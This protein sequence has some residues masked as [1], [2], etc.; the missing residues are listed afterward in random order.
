MYVTINE[1][2][3]LFR[4]RSLNVAKALVVAEQQGFCAQSAK[5]TCA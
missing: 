5:G 4:L 2:T 3:G 1:T